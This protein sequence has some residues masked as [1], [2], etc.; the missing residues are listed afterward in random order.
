VVSHDI[1]L[2]FLEN[3]FMPAL[4]FGKENTVAVNDDKTKS[5]VIYQNLFLDVTEIKV[6]SA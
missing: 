2:Q 5:F 4:D 3:L 6:L 1:T